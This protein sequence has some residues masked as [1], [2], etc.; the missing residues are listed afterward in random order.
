MWFLSL[1]SFLKTF[2]TTRCISL[3]L[4]SSFKLSL[5]PSSFY[6][7]SL[8]CYLYQSILLHKISTALFFSFSS[9]LSLVRSLILP[10]CRAEVPAGTL[11]SWCRSG[12]EPARTA[13]DTDL[14][15]SRIRGAGTTEGEH[16]RGKWEVREKWGKKGAEQSTAHLKVYT[17]TLTNLMKLELWI[18]IH[19]KINMINETE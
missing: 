10:S 2:L 6:I 14:R 18:L 7:S 4:V 12:H 13:G 1:S 16:S 3:T 5:S 9:S 19:L 11:A 15:K 17:L 8:C